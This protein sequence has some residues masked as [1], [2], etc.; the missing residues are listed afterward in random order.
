[1]FIGGS[2]ALLVWCAAFLPLLDTGSI[3][4]AVIAFLGMGLI[5]PVTHSV[6]GAIIADLF[7]ASVRYSGTSLVLQV[8]AILGGG[9]APIISSALVGESGG[10]AGVTVY[11]TVLCALSLVCAA[12]LFRT[13]AEAPTEPAEAPT[14]AV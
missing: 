3:A 1:M 5:V 6:Q 14:A 8:G 13:R 12:I 2:V 11:L 9:L 10:S 7:P 4:L